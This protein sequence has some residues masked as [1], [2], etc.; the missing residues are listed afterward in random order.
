MGAVFLTQKKKITRIVRFISTSALSYIRTVR[1]EPLSVRS[2][3]AIE[4]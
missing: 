3:I 2:E 4:Q 1:K